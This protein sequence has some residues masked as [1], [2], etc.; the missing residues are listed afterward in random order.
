MLTL[1]SAHFLHINEVRCEVFVPP[2]S[3]HPDTTALVAWLF[4]LLGCRPWVDN[5]LQEALGMTHHTVQGV[6][7]KRRAG[8]H[9]VSY[10]PRFVQRGERINPQKTEN[11]SS[12]F[13]IRGVVLLNVGSGIACKCRK[14]SRSSRQL[15]HYYDFFVIIVT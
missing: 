5:P 2:F 9:G 13:L 15:L 4:L 7:E 12:S 14:Q 8:K 1:C 3:H 10:D 11:F 6:G